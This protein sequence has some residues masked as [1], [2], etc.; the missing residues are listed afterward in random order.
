[1][2][3]AQA[4]AIRASGL[5]DFRGGEYGGDVVSIPGQRFSRDAQT[6]LDVEGRR[7]DVPG[8]GIRTEGGAGVAVPDTRARLPSSG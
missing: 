3:Q 6:V 1:M 8:V 4:D 7:V 2:E 5:R